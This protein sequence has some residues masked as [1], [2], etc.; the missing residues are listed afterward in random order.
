MR[1]HSKT[2]G[3][4]VHLS[5]QKETITDGRTLGPKLQEYQSKDKKKTKHP[6]TDF[7]GKVYVGIEDQ[8]QFSLFLWYNK[9]DESDP[10]YCCV[11]VQ[12]DGKYSRGWT[13]QSGRKNGICID[14]IQ[15][16]D[17]KFSTKE[18]QSFGTIQAT[19]W[20]GTFTF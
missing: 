2:C 20:R 15:Q 17:L 6:P 10:D 13:L 4:T 3:L 18:N 19:F 8:T 14:K 11:D 9:Q 16:K 5:N 12:V 1:N 7:Y